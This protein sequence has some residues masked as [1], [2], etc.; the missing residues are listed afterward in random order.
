VTLGSSEDRH[1]GEG[2]GKTSRIR[3]TLILVKKTISSLTV[4][5]AQRI[6]ERKDAYKC[7]ERFSQAVCQ[8]KDLSGEKLKLLMRLHSDI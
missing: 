3:L 8:V 1:P 7:S 5:E 2:V 6:D 4:A